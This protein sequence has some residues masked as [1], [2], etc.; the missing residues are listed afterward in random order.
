MRLQLMSL[1]FCT[2]AAFVTPTSL[3][4][5]RFEVIDMDRN[6]VDKLLI[7]SRSIAGYGYEI[8]RQ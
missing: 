5:Y 3:S 6:R 2:P 4:G 1:P 7:T 8:I